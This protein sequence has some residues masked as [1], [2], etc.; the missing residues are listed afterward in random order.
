MTQGKLFKVYR[1][2][3]GS[4]KTFTLV[5]EYL[6]LCL[7]QADPAYFSRILAITFTNKAAEE[8]KERVL[9]NLKGIAEGEGSAHFNKGMHE[10]LMKELDLGA[11]ELAARCS[12]IYRTM[13]HHYGDLAIST[14][15]KF[16]HGLIRSFAR[17]LR[18]APDFEVDIDARGLISRA[19]DELL[20]RVGTDAEVTNLLTRFTE[21]QVEDEA[22]WKI[23]TA[24]QNL[25]AELLK[26]SAIQPLESL[27]KIPSDVF[28]ELPAQLK[29]QI[30]SAEKILIDEALGIVRF[31]ESHSLDSQHFSRGMLPNWLQHVVKGEFKLYGKTIAASIESGIWSAKSLRSPE[32]EKIEDCSEELT[33]LM[34]SFDE[35]FR[36]TFAK[37]KIQKAILTFYYP[38]ITLR[39]I[40]SAIEDLKKME[41][42]LPISEFNRMVA[43]IVASSPAPFIFERIGERYNHF[44]IDEFQD[45]SVLQWQNFIPLIENGLSKGFFSMLVGDGKQAIYRW[46]NGEVEQ[47]IKL[48]EIFKSDGN[49]ELKSKELILRRNYEAAY[50]ENNFRSGINIIEFNNKLFELLRAHI[51]DSELEKIYDR[52]AQN[53]KRK[54]EGVV[55]IDMISKSS[56]TVEMQRYAVLKRHIDICL[57]QGYRKSDIAILC[58]R[59]ADCKAV[60]SFLLS[61]KLP[62]ITADSLTIVGDPEVLAVLA[63]LKLREDYRDLS[64]ALDLIVC[65]HLVKKQEE[66]TFESIQKYRK[67]RKDKV[68]QRSVAWIDTQEFLRDIGIENLIEVK[69]QEGLFTVVEKILKALGFSVATNA[70]LEFFME[71]VF[72]FS[73]RSNDVASFLEWWLEKGDSAEVRVSQSL[74]AIQIMTIH[75]SKGLQFPVVIIPYLDAATGN[76]VEIMWPELED[77]APPLEVA[78]L[79]YSSKGFEDT[80]LEAFMNQETARKNLDDLNSFYVACTRPEDRLYLITNGANNPGKMLVDAIEKMPLSKMEEGVFIMGKEEMPEVKADATTVHSEFNL[81]FVARTFDSLELSLEAPENW[82]VDRPVG[83]RDKGTLYH[84]ILAMIRTVDELDIALAKAAQMHDLSTLEIAELKSVIMPFITHPEIQFW[85]EKE[86]EILVETPFLSK[87]GLLLRPDRIRLEQD[88]IYLID[89]KTG[90]HR[91]SYIKQLNRYA[92]ILEEVFNR[93]VKSFIGYINARDA[94][95]KL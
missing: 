57:E 77:E 54:F 7:S 51:G 76:H 10:T 71:H 29:Q 13:L 95:F 20:S 30:A 67:L 6:R 90:N 15:D 3:A 2:S 65:W 38:M 11:E 87:E 31:L 43:G 59:K 17:D 78:A 86:A 33:A 32:K 23:R 16:I 82:N 66:S 64:A 92:A 5:K 49:S 41:G 73:Q 24:L 72:Q 48:P 39:H 58:R 27:G 4:G 81:D 28:I 62:V 42:I 18:L 80:R 56:E 36:K 12:D 89:F 88:A 60:A 68:N 79:R 70:Y 93:P 91:E 83:R 45:T 1:S 69:A 84:E 14:I 34:R 37:I 74:D 85:F 25:S 55:R 9:D 61:H 19:V 26:E 21:S 50:L 46:R 75:K 52:H 22:D 8:M 53:I 94:V 35:V 44:L 40:S 63:M 47:F